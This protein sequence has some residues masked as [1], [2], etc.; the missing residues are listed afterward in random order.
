MGTWGSF[1]WGFF[2]GLCVGQAALAVLLGVF[3]KDSAAER[4]YG[5]PTSAAS[6]HETLIISSPN[7][8]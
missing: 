6:E 2:L 1:A 3:R 8:Y 5:K 4:D 7:R